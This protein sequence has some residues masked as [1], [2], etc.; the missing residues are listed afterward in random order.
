MCGITGFFK[1]SPNSLDLSNSTKK[2]L[3]MLSHRGPDD[4]GIWSDKI[5][6]ISLGHR[7]LAILDLSSAGHQPMHSKCNRFV[8]VFN[9]EIYNHMNIRKVLES[10]TPK[11]IE[12]KGHS[13]TETLL[14]AIV[15]WGVEKA[16]NEC[17]GMFS[18]ALWD[19]QEKILTMA[20]DR[21]G[22]KPLYYG[23]QGDTFMFAS[24][25]KA[26]KVHSDFIG[27]ID[28]NSLTLFLRYNYVPVPNSIYKGIKKL[29]P[30]NFLQLSFSSKK[31]I[32]IK[33]YWSLTSV[34]K[35]GQ[36][37]PLT[38]NDTEALSLFES[39]LDQAIMSQQIS[40]VP[41]GAFLSG[42]VDS[43]LIVSMMQ[44][45]SSKAIKTFTIGFEN[46]EFNE[47]KYAKAIAEHLG[48]HHSEL[49]ISANDAL[50]VI[51]SIPTLYDEP[52]ADSSQIPTFLVAKMA[53]Q[54]V[55]VALSGDG[56][57]ELFGGYNRHIW[58]RR[59]HNKTSWL[60]KSARQR[61]GSVF[62]SISAEH[63][64]TINNS[65]SG[66]LPFKYRSTQLGDKIHKVA[67][68]L[69]LDN[70]LEIYKGLVSQWQN[71]LDLVIGGTE[72]NTKKTSEVLEKMF[73]DTEHRMMFMDTKTYLPDDILCK[74]DRASMAVGLETRVPF[75]NHSL[76]EFA[77]QLPLHM[78]IRD[79]KGKWIL[80]ELLS[81]HVPSKLIERPKQGF[82][83]PIAEWLRG[84]LREWAE[85]LLDE[86]RIK[87]DGFFNPDPISNAWKNHLKGINMHNQ[88]WGVLMFQAWLDDNK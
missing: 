57:D 16:L 18:I 27:E 11:I 34:A 61:L 59:I 9:G 41:I 75:L 81:K 71:P 84:P 68:L 74:V 60:S 28:R 25:L 31:K 14:A 10:S 50:N 51:P 53:S 77:W 26:L 46:S 24:E 80:R 8:L 5:N 65:F 64:N 63:W 15:E 32:A 56:G 19:K 22:E 38:C 85:E 70:D 88:L 29:P 20:R 30:G 3:D 13:D 35:K 12:W 62:S 33:S 43:S 1:D 47:A 87:N 69:N 23:W 83:L 44:S 48:T 4:Y 86:S 78:K 76:V 6:Q 79:G 58:S 17:V 37:K 40:D 2:M 42:G 54:D 52:F 67:N 49:Y 36:T 21:M 7:R 82:A 72:Y 73:E 66:I 55:K 39:H 45:Q